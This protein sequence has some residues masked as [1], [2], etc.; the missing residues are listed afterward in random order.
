MD[1]N[2]YFI[3]KGP[4]KDHYEVID[5]KLDKQLIE[6]LDLQKDSCDLSTQVTISGNFLVILV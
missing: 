3:F 2:N 6:Y 5:F 1:S 4:E